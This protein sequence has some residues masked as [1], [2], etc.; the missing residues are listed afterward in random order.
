MAEEVKA[1]LD[2]GDF[3]KTVVSVGCGMRIKLSDPSLA[4]SL[5]LRRTSEVVRSDNA[6]CLMPHVS[7]VKGYLGMLLTTTPIP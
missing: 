6:S 1:D 4:S 3:A 2:A 7:L 5:P